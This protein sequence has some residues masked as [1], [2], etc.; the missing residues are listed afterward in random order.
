MV[1]TAFPL[2]EVTPHE[3]AKPSMLSNIR[4]KE[5]WE[6]DKS[7][8]YHKKRKDKR[9]YET[10]EQE[11][12]HSSQH[13][14]MQKEERKHAVLFGSNM[15]SSKHLLTNKCQSKRLRKCRK[16]E[17]AKTSGIGEEDGNL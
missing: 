14:F 5:I 11:R 17:C 10:G 1:S 16:T 3:P 15:P 7:N 8:N 12:V 9:G 4:G 6:E 2:H 13:F